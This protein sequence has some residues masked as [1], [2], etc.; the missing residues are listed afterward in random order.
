MS[1]V[2]ETLDL[3]TRLEKLHESIGDK[4]P[5]ALLVVEGAI[6][7]IGTVSDYN[8]LATICNE[9]KSYDWL[10]PVDSFINES[11]KFAKENELA[12]AV[13]NTLENIRTSKDKKSFAAAINSLE[14]IKDLSES[15][16][17]KAIPSRMKSHSWVPG[18]KQLVEM[19]ELRSGSNKT[20]DKRFTNTR[21]VSP[22]LE[23]ENGETI[24]SVGNRVYAMNES[25]EIRLA[26]NNEISEEFVKLTQLS[27]N[28][29]ITEDGLRHSS[30]NCNIDINRVEEGEET[31]TEVYVDGQLVK[32]SQL[33]ATLMA[34]GKFRYGQYDTIKVL[35]HALNKI[36]N[37]YELDFV[38][39]IK[40]NVYEGV[41]V[42]VMRTG[43]GL[44]VNK[45][46]PSMNENTLIKPETATDAI[47]LVQEFVDY[48]ITNSVQDIL[49]GEAK[50]EADRNKTEE[51]IYERID[52]IKNEISKLSELNMDDMTEIKEAKKVL[53]DALLKEQDRL[54]KMF[55]SK[56]VTMHEASDADFAPGELKMKI[57]GYKP[58]TKVQINA[59]Q[60]TSGG[61][62]DMISV[63]LPSN[64]IVEVQK[65][66]LDVAI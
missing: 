65:K 58:G 34:N 28:F 30:N 16:L 11:I 57:N 32:E 12:F 42:N 61:T 54:N 33:A 27:E 7:R 31:K 24:F 4:T 64:E 21:P 2:V 51:N 18:I 8:N 50:I 49:E 41:E 37:L 19:S 55:R 15:E 25:E 52:Y 23:N 66:Y 35:E 56:N 63:I 26:H 44:Y 48:D 39:T 9:M 53:N 40:S 14:E 6:R 38:E 22:V 60:F 46:N 3:R 47:N 13:L 45:I 36:D 62:K 5:G 29:T 17:K 10:A 43:N 20:T 59:G 1:K